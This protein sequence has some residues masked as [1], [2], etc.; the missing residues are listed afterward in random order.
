[1]SSLPILTFDERALSPRL[2]YVFDRRWLDPFES[3][4]GMVWKFVRMNGIAGHTM[5]TQLC[6]HVD[7]YEGAV[8]A[9]QNVDVR[10]LARMLGVTQSNVRAGLY[11]APRDS[12]RLK[13]CTRCLSRGYHGA[14]HQHGR[15]LCCPAHGRPLQTLCRHC[16]RPSEYRLDA[17]LL[18]SPFRCRHCSRYLAWPPPSNLAHRRPMTL[19][20]RVAMIRTHLA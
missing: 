9:P 1:M 16:Q 17:Q 10:A 19:K 20:E 15:L 12:A 6:R 11:S 2:G 13:Y 3:I 18:D 5:M 8:P 7:P 14:S 4:V